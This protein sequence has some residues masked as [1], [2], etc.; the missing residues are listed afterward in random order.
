MTSGSVLYNIL[1]YDPSVI[2]SQPT[3]LFVCLF[4]CFFESL[5]K[6]YR[7]MPY[8]RPYL[9]CGTKRCSWLPM[10]S[11]RSFSVGVCAVLLCLSWC[12]L[13]VTLCRGAGPL[14]CDHGVEVMRFTVDERRN[15]AHCHP[16]RG[17]RTEN[18][19][20]PSRGVPLQSMYSSS[21]CA[22][23]VLRRG[24]VVA[25]VSSVLGYLSPVDAA[26]SRSLACTPRPVWVPGSVIEVRS[27]DA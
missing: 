7:A 3:C 1:T 25:P 11:Q 12:V 27:G 18:A 6:A 15:P 21:M 4:V 9:R 10:L 20:L 5:I 14:R 13:S 2:L 26:A 23:P 17:S 19:S 24:P 22:R 16:R 8:A